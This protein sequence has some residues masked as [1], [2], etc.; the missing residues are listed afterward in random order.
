MDLASSLDGKLDYADYAVYSSLLPGDEGYDVI[1]SHREGF[2][3]NFY[4]EKNVPKH[5]T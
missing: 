1:R 3:N 2:Y 5:P 4:A